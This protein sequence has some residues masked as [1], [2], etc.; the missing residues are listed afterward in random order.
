[1][2]EFEKTMFKGA[3][4]PQEVEHSFKCGLRTVTSSQRGQREREDLTMATA[5]KQDLGQVSK[6][7]IPAIN[8]ADSSH[9][10]WG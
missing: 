3:S 10:R 4:P 2:L 6:V 1:M 5:D 8:H 9:P 7:S